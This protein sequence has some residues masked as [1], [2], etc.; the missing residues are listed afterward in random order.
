[1]RLVARCYMSLGQRCSLLV[2][3]G[4]LFMLAG[5]AAASNETIPTP[6]ADVTVATEQPAAAP[7]N[8]G[9]LRPGDQIWLISTRS[10]DC[11][12]GNSEPAYEVMRYDGAA[13]QSSTLTEFLAADSP[14]L[15]TD[16]Y[17]HGNFETDYGAQENGL[18]IYSRLVACAAADR[19]IRFVIWSWPSDPG[20]HKVRLIREHADRADVDAWYLG[21]LLNRINPRVPL[22]L[23]GY[24]FGARIATG[25][26]H[27][28]GGGEMC[29]MAL[30]LANPAPKRS[31]RV[32]LVAAAEDCDTLYPGGANGN[33][34]SVVDRMLMLNNGCDQALRLYPHLDKCCPA[35][36]LG[37]VG[38]GGNYPN[39][40]Q[41][42]ACCTIGKKHDWRLYFCNDCLVAMMRPYLYLDSLEPMA[43]VK[44]AGV[45]LASA[46]GKCLRERMPLFN[47]VK[48]SNM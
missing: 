9:G 7:C 41:F 15:P 26:L 33:A 25:A 30:A 12:A 1:M 36:A 20:H 4:L 3:A 11:P 35:D 23:I 10:L 17:I 28:L 46:V 32:V 8:C 31:I 34:L 24:S 16:F 6:P 19:P 29:G 38:L 14:S 48:L 40:A 45:A 13:W 27:L 37:Y 2:A 43:A 5:S 22:G 42:D 39:V 44:R 18:T 47:E 21:S